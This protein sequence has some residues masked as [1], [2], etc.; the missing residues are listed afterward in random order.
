MGEG[1]K[2]SGGII[3]KAIAQNWDQSTFYAQLRE[4][5]AYE[6]GPEYQDNKAKMQTVFESIYGKADQ[7]A[8]DWIKNVT[9]KGWTPDEAASWLRSQD[10]YKLTPEYR[11]KALS[12]ASALGLVTGAV[13]TLSTD[14]VDQM[15][16]NDP[17]FGASTTGGPGAQPNRPDNKPGPRGAGPSTVAYP[18]LRPDDRAGVRR[19]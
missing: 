1:W 19:P 4:T 12:F 6:K 7:G 17:S 14:Q 16:H 11:S 3:R 5:P 15:M 2:P 18:N 8:Q 13:P 10:A 9:L